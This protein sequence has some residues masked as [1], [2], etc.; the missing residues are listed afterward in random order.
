MLWFFEREGLQTRVEVLHL[1]D[2]TYELRVLDADEAEH[3]ERFTNAAELA[4]SQ[5]AIQDALIA[6]GW[7]RSGEWLV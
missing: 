4:K 1:P 3:V 7:Q 6:N 2:G 5:Q